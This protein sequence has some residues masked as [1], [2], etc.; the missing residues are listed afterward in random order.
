MLS[1]ELEKLID[2]A[3]A[4][5]VITEQEMRVLQKK[6]QETGADWDEFQMV[7]EARLFQAQQAQKAN[8][9]PVPPVAPPVAPPASAPRQNNRH[10]SVKKCPNCGETVESGSPVCKACGFAFQGIEANS[11]VKRLAQMIN[12][13]TTKKYDMNI[14]SGTPE[15]KKMEA[16]NSII[17]TFPV[18]T[19]KED[20]LE[21]ILYTKSKL[22]DEVYGGSYFMKYKECIDKA[23][24]LF[25]D[26]RQMQA[27]VE[28][29]KGAK[30]AMSRQKKAIIGLVSFFVFFLL[31][32]II[33][34]IVA[35]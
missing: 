9:T 13:A 28:D 3:V 33:I 11:S 8:N 18:P 1:P 20:L 19:T 4:D 35:I 29:S 23:R 26:D 12:E 32:L 25:P 2:L 6:V 17:V 21:F 30:A 15:M 10:G 5:G 31:L 22:S 34:I 24:F 16:I 14:F 27:L 7:L